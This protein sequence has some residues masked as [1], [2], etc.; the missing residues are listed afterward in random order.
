MKRQRTRPR[1][2]LHAADHRPDSGPTRGLRSIAFGAAALVR[3]DRARP[4]GR[5]GR[6]D[7]LRLRRGNYLRARRNHN[8]GTRLG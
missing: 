8:V 2:R 7:F 1:A 3:D 5:R 6:W 4:L